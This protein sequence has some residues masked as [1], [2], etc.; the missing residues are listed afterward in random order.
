MYSPTRYP[1]CCTA[2]ASV[3]IFAPSQLLEGLRHDLEH[4]IA[5][6]GTAVWAGCAPLRADAG[7]GIRL[8]GREGG[9]IRTLS[10]ELHDFSA[11]FLGI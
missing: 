11:M 7:L 1:A 2:F 8:A 6:G 5:R 9:R 3:L 10:R 4:L